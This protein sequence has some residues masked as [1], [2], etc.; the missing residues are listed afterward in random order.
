M[1][2][3]C[4]GMSASPA[5]L[6]FMSFTFADLFA[7]IGGFH[8]ALSPLGGECVFVSE[9]DK[10][11]AETYT[12]HWLQDSDVEVSGDIRTLTEGVVVA[13][14]KH[15][16]LTGGFPCQPFSYAGKQQGFVDTRGTLFFEIERLLKEHRP[17]GFL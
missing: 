9:W 5:K 12:A 17:M 15:D 8:A 7:G 6:P 14:P 2:A 13:V 4:R 16:V 11:A 1:W 10:Y 3:A